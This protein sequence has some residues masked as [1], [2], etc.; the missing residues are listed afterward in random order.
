MTFFIKIIT[1]IIHLFRCFFW[2][3]T[4]IKVNNF[5]FTKFDFEVPD[6]FQEKRI[7]DPFFHIIPNVLKV[8]IMTVK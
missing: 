1:K 6:P 7:Q 5:I 8:C 3:A 2:T 4:D